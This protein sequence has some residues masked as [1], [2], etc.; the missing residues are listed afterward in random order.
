MHLEEIARELGI[1]YGTAKLSYESLQDK[2]GYS[3]RIEIGTLLNAAV[4]EKLWRDS[5]DES[6]Q[7]PAK[8]VGR[9]RR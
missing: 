8:V 1:A 3:G 9:L 2:T 7:T 4:R 6:P 5:D